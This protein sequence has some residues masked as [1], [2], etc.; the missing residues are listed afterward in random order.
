MKRWLAL[1][2]ALLLS[3]PALA[4][5]RG[6][7]V[8]YSADGVNLHGY[9]AWDDSVSGPRPGVIVVHEWWGHN[10]YVR[11]RARQLAALGYTALAVDMFGDG[12]T[13]DHPDNAGAF[14]REVAQNADIRRSRFNAAMDVLNAHP[15]VKN[16]QLAALGYCFGGS[17]VLNM[18]REGA[19]LAGVVAYHAG[20]A[21]PVAAQAG[22]TQSRVRVF[23][24]AAD[25]MVPPEQVAAF[26]AE[27]RASGVDFSVVN[28]DGVLHGFTNP[29]ADAF[30]E[31]FGL[32]LGFDEAADSDSWAQTQSFLQE[33]FA[34]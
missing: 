27:M 34:Q 2:L 1:P 4:E 21:S 23:N 9:I 11:D 25:P 7:E 12:R 32:P 26:E 31:R 30:A 5:I 19:P 28:Y 8:R 29:G 6:E 15:T 20:L 22:V 17:V 33:L 14:A 10:D 24:G 16:D 13:A 3:S 18:A